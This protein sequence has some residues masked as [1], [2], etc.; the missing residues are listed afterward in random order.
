[1]HYTIDAPLALNQTILLP[2]SKSISNRVLIMNKLAQSKMQPENISD[3]DD[4]FVMQR[5]LR[6]HEKKLRSL[7]GRL[8]GK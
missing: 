6:D 2:S 5:A 1:M 8:Y 3:C 4:T 7:I